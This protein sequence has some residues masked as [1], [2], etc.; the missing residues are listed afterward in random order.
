MIRKLV[1]CCLLHNNH[2]TFILKIESISSSSLHI[3][4]VDTVYSICLINGLNV[5]ILN[6][7]IHMT[8]SWEN[9]AK[10]VPFPR[11]KRHPEDYY[12]EDYYASVELSIQSSLVNVLWLLF[13]HSSPCHFSSNNS[14][15][16]GC[17]VW[18]YSPEGGGFNEGLDYT[19]E[20]TMIHIHSPKGSRPSL[21]RGI[22]L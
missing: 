7:Y 2:I 16:A 17:S 10:P 5:D 4:V 8:R 9:K 1:Y 12:Y 20:E 3:Y 14:M 18:W 15:S 22:S 19:S 13:L 11:F 6:K 21:L